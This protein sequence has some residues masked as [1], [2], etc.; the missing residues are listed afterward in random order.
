MTRDDLRRLCLH[1]YDQPGCALEGE[2]I[3]AQAREVGK[4]ILVSG[5][6]S[7]RMR[8]VVLRVNALCVLD[9][10]FRTREQGLR[11]KTT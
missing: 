11:I 5:T 4:A 2:R 7:H 3:V 8:E 6:S 9:R 1:V 10:A